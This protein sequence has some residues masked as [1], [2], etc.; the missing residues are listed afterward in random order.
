MSFLAFR[1]LKTCR[2]T[3]ILKKIVK[4]TPFVLSHVSRVTPMEVGTPKIYGPL[5]STMDNTMI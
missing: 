3:K 2:N 1:K 4:C 5:N